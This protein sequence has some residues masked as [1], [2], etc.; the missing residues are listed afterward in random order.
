MT[1]SR[2]EGAGCLW[3]QGQL[4]L[5]QQLLPPMQ[6]QASWDSAKLQLLPRD[7]CTCWAGALGHWQGSTASQALCCSREDWRYPCNHSPC[8]PSTST[9]Q[10]GHSL[11]PHPTIPQRPPGQEPMDASHLQSKGLRQV[12]SCCS[13]IPMLQM[14]GRKAPGPAEYLLGEGKQPQAV[15]EGAD[16][17][18]DCAWVYSQVGLHVQRPRGAF[19]N[20]PGPSCLNGRGAACLA[21]ATSGLHKYCTPAQPGQSRT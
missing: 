6:A 13:S 10:T 2:E 16:W 12:S 11:N 19:P 4:W 1:W 5:M 18:G 21:P 7:G 8:H 17:V 3:P 20:L 15:A 14:P 9:D